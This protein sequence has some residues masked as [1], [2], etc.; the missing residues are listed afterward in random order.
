MKLWI[1][2]LRLCFILGVTL[3]P[4]SALR[5]QTTRYVS[6]DGSND[7]AGGYASW[8]GAA[9][10]IPNAITAAEDGDL[11]LVS[12][13]TYNL[14]EQIG[15]A[16]IDVAKRVT[17]RGFS[18]NREAVVINGGAAKQGFG[19]IS[20]GC[21]GA[22]L[23][24]L[25]VSNCL[26]TLTGGG[27]VMQRDAY[28]AITITNVLIVNNRATRGG[29]AYISGATVTDCTFLNNVSPEGT[30]YN[31]SGGGAIY[32]PY[33]IFV[34][35]QFIGN[36]ANIVYTNS[37]TDGF[38][39]AIM[40]REHRHGNTRMENCTFLHNYAERY[41]GA[42][43]DACLDTNFPASIIN[44]TIA[45]NTAESIGGGVYVNSPSTET[46]EG[47][48]IRDNIS[49]VYGGGV[50]VGGPYF[51]MR[52]VELSGN[53]APYGGGININAGGSNLIEN[54]LIIGN[55]ATNSAGGGLYIAASLNGPML[56]N[57][58]IVSNTAATSAG[59]VAAISGGRFINC[60]IAHNTA[61][62]DGGGLYA[63]R[64]YV[65]GGF[66]AN[67]TIVSNT[68][69]LGGGVHF[70]TQSTSISNWFT[71]SIVYH[72]RSLSDPAR[73]DIWFN[74]N[75]T[76]AAAQSNQF[77]YCCAPIELPAANGNITNEP[78]F[79]DRPAG[80]FRLAGGSLCI[81]SG[82]NQDW[83]AEV[84]D[85]DGRLRRDRFS[86]LVDRGCYEHIARGS[87]FSAH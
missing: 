57:C 59:G 25:T 26:G 80:N 50:M 8:S 40:I 20:A 27:I 41:G 24:R 67:C 3:S 1:S 22:V 74:A 44:C 58:T 75:A 34:N 14:V 82:V 15:T 16:Y 13:G 53:R 4:L 61:A 78:G 48:V 29:G 5:A 21:V 63:Q 12:N 9:T 73:S 43:Y 83:M 39:G 36:R 6:L 52:N 71:N 79:V 69:A 77:Y 64:M 37:A 85:L 55:Q 35:C 31:L 66:V 2:A 49:Y 23:E 7:T 42:V 70:S 19:F 81:N 11:I 60:L 30:S 65:A 86:G 72:N 62:T 32:T 54:C 46:I 47:G 18:A 56:R 33:G 76:I 51:Q 10:N 68:A 84:P 28:R 87:L 38:G 45:S 17:I